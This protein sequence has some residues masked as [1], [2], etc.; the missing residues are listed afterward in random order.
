MSFYIRPMEERD[1]GSVIGMMKV[2]YSSEAVYTNGSK[3]VFESDFKSCVSENPFAE[4]FVFEEG[5]NLLG[6]AMVAKSFSTEF[7]KQCIWL[8]DIFVKAEH[9]G[10]GVGSAFL[11]FA[12]SRYPDA[13]LRLEIEPENES[14]IRLYQKSGFDFLPYSEMIKPL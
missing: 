12:E 11:E 5:E 2:F 8:E 14:A 4:G 9:R 1:K 10:K 7:G 13:V 3:E 6:Y